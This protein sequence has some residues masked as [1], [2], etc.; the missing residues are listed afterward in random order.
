MI[1]GTSILAV[2]ALSQFMSDEMWPVRSRAVEIALAESLEDT[3]E[4]GPNNR[5]ARIDTYLENGGQLPRKA[6]KPGIGWCGMFIYFCYTRAALESGITLPDELRISF[7]SGYRLGVW[8][9]ANGKLVKNGHL[10]PGDIYTR[11]EHWHI[12][13]IIEPV[14]NPTFRTVIRTIDGNQSF[15]G[16]RRNSVQ[17]RTREFGEMR[18]VIRL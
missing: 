2:N 4:V 10:L 3:R 5:G 15:A 1:V 18:R 14:S 9:K 17:V 8:A 13:M 12:G 7:L 11:R 6:D 16:S